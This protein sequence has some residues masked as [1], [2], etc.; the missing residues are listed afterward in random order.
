MRHA[1][2]DVVP[3]LD[4]TAGPLKPGAP[5]VARAVAK[6]MCS[7]KS[8]AAMRRCSENKNLASLTKTSKMSTMHALRRIKL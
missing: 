5:S 3:E 1:A 2:G 4:P 6:C 8:M 7:S